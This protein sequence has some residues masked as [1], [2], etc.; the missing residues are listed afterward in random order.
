M[1][2]PRPLPLAA[3]NLAGVLQQPA[4]LLHGGIAMYRSPRL[5]EDIPP[6]SR[7]PVDDE[8]LADG[9]SGAAL[10]GGTYSTSI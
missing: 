1:P 2:L 7:V 4:F 8:L 6:R 3:S 9:E 10:F 5:A